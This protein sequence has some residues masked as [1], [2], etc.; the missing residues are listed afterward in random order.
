MNIDQILQ[1]VF[2]IEDDVCRNEIAV[3][4]VSNTSNDQSLS[5]RRTDPNSR[6]LL[7]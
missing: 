4:L 3:N 5:S 2:Q 7:Y 6:I 1:E